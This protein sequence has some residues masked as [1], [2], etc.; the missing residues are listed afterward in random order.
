MW[1]YL[2]DFKGFFNYIMHLVGPPN[3]LA[4]GLSHCI[5]GQLLNTMGIHLLC[6]VHGG[7]R[8]ASHDSMH[9]AFASIARDV[10][11]HILCE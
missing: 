2:I 10:R 6:Y 9:D 5:C 8:M 7:E 4:F 3:P 1:S 11:F